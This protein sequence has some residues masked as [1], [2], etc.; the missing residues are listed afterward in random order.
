M[1]GFTKYNRP[2][3]SVI[4]KDGYYIIQSKMN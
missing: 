4:I 2:I 1:K 3:P